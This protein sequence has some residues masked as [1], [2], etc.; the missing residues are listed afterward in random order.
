[1]IS[2]RPSYA[3]HIEL[4][5]KRIIENFIVREICLIFFTSWERIDDPSLPCDS[6]MANYFYP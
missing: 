1:M 3:G 6:F 2:F 5:A 4:D